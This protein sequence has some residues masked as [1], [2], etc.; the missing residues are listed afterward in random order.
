M[1]KARAL[2]PGISE[3]RLG[4]VI[5]CCVA[6]ASFTPLCP[7]FSVGGMMAFPWMAVVGLK[8][9]KDTKA[10]C[11]ADTQWLLLCSP[12]LQSWSGSC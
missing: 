3:M 4:S 11:S 2:E 5:Y 12:F 6:K 10:L 7:G 1:E 9:L 8:E